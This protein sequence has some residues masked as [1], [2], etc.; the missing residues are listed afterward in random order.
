MHLEHP[1]R[2]RI[3]IDTPLLK[4]EI[5]IGNIGLEEAVTEAGGLGRRIRIFRLPDELSDIAISVD[6]IFTLSQGQDN[7]LYAKVVQEDGH[8]AWSSPIYFVPG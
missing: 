2:G 5:D 7:P 3:R 1:S 4:F 8:A 6:R